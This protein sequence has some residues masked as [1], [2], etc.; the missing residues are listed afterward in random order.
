[1]TGELSFLTLG[2]DFVLAFLWL[3][4]AVLAFLWLA[5]V[6]IR[7]VFQIAS[8]RQSSRRVGFQSE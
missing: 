4:L 5:V 3:T 2:V 6:G 7:S 1:M 8:T